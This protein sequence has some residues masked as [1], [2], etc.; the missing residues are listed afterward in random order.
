MFCMGFG[1]ECLCL[2][3]VVECDVVVEW[4]VEI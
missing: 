4:F 3:F 2:E 1:G